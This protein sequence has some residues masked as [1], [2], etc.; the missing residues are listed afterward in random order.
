MD[1]NDINNDDNIINESSNRDKHH[2]KH[3]HAYLQCA[4]RGAIHVDVV[5]GVEAQRDTRGIRFPLL[6]RS[7]QRAC[8][9]L[10]NT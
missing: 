8:L 6:H 10:D 2:L 1:N 3:T 4:Q 9:H 7:A 5:V